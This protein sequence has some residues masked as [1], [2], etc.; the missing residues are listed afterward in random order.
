M[1][2]SVQSLLLSIN[3]L[4][5]ALRRNRHLHRGSKNEA[6]AHFCFYLWN[7][8][9][10]SDNFWHTWAAVYSKYSAV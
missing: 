1:A 6:N 9:V 8:S 3:V 5:A 10:K 4:P 2:R 7:T